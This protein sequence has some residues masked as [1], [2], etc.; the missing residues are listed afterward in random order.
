[1]AGFYLKYNSA[2]GHW[3][4]TRPE[5]DVSNPSNWATADSGSNAQTGTWT[6][7]TGV[8]NAGTG[9][10][11]L[12]VDGTDVA[13]KGGVDG[14]DTTPIASHGPVEI[15][16][17][18]W[19]GQTGWGN[20][21]GKIANVE[22]YPTALSAAEVSNLEQQ[23]NPSAQN[24]GGD[25]VRGGLTTS[26]AVDQL[27]QVTAQTNPDGQ[28]SSF[29]YDPAGHQTKVTE[30]QVVTESSAG[31]PSVTSGT[32]PTGYNTFGDTAQTQDQ[33]GN[34]TTYTYNGDGRQLS[35][36]PPVLHPARPVQPRSTAP[37]RRRTPR[38]DRSRRRPTRT[39]TRRR[40]PT[41]SSATRRA[42]KT[43]P[44][45][46]TT[47]P[48]TTPTGTW[49]RETSP[50]GGQTH[51]HLRLPRPAGHLNQRRAVPDAG[52]HDPVLAGVLHDDDVLHARHGR[53]ERAPGRP[54]PPS[55]DGV[56]TS[57]EYDA[58]GG[59]HTVH[60]RR[61]QRHRL[62]L[63]R[64]RAARS[65]PLTRTRP[66]TRSPTTRPGTWSPS[67]ASTPA[68]RPSPPRP[69]PT[70]ARATSSPRRTRTATP[71]PITYDPMGDLTAETQPVT[72]A[73]GIVTS[74]GYDP[75]GN[76]TAYTDG[77]GNLWGTTYNS[78]N[79]PA[80]PGRAVHQPVLDR[81]EHPRPPSPTTATGSRRR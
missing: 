6:F 52:V 7:L 77:N 80:D 21:D 44:R 17:A 19:D 51:V 20:F 4:F 3:Q 60:R 36:D 29:A 46:A 33:N 54:R 43:T 67:P 63:R 55:P 38:S 71:P 69:R 76:Q 48:P 42:W 24:F 2:N 68:G 64:P 27:G 40:T 72:S 49:R 78:W 30:P 56:T 66:R 13:A 31:A 32:T 23:A 26:Y 41:T 75:A 25:I 1:M 70:T 35:A 81:G 9:A 58:V 57:Y 47:S 12:Y 62:R 65:Q 59:P 61:E 14:N 53:S 28:T 34:I 22:V 73:A 79:L 10:V 8:Y 50:T 45:G 37:A 5:A 18:K 15:G 11:Q 16:A 74:F 39:T